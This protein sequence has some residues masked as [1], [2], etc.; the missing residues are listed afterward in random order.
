MSLQLHVETWLSVLRPGQGLQ[1]NPGVDAGPGTP[2]QLASGKAA[3]S[4]L[5]PPGLESVPLLRLARS[6]RASVEIS[7]KKQCSQSEADITSGSSL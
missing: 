4:Q 1:G 6:A 5:H 7:T 2:D 3:R